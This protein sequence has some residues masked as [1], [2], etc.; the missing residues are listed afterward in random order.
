MSGRSG[1]PFW[2]ANKSLKLSYVDGTTL[3]GYYLVEDSAPETHVNH[4]K[5]QILLLYPEMMF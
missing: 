4:I 2:G 5:M 3:V 1:F